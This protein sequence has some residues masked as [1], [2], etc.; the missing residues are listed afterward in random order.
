V[1]LE[2][3]RSW[4]YVTPCFFRQLLLSDIT[5]AIGDLVSLDIC[6]SCKFTALGG[7]GKVLLLPVPRQERSQ[8]AM[9][10]RPRRRHD[11]DSGDN[12]DGDYIDDDPMTATIVTDNRGGDNGDETHC[13][14]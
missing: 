14:S 2:R 6:W 1:Q 8:G 3:V 9:R 10:Q 4:S 5:E 13:L 12:G 11:R 7:E